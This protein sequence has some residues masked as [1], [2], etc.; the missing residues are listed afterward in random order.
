LRVKAV[1]SSFKKLVVESSLEDFQFQP[2]NKDQVSYYK[3][4]ATPERRLGAD[5]MVTLHELAYSLPE[6]VWSI[7]T[8]PDFVAC[9]GMPSMVNLVQSCNSVL[10]SYDTTFQL[11][12]FY[13]S[14]MVLKLSAFHEEPSIPVGFV[15]HDR[16]FQTVHEEF[17]HQLNRR[18]KVKSNVVLVSDG[19]A[20]ITSAFRVCYPKWFL[21]NCW[22]HILT[23]V[24]MWLKRH[25][26]KKSDIEVYKSNVRELLQCT[27]AGEMN[28]KFSTLE[29][30]WSE[31]FK[32]YYNSHLLDRVETAYTGYLQS[33]GLQKNSITTNMSESLN[34]VIKDFQSWQESTADICLLSM[35]RLQ[36]YYRVV[37][38][39]SVEGFGPYSLLVDHDA[40]KPIS[41]IML[42][43]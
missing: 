19:E 18:L 6:F 42:Y 14:V 2:R 10:L 13:L 21:V 23:D 33:V 22:N 3:C 15:L 37:I 16:K 24:E 30:S 40:G 31:S 29:P 17:C 25:D 20:A 8:F 39:R 27:S 4:I 34:F 9:F 36:L 26:G 11:G 38:L 35:Y 7:K 5:T 41:E 32:T 1:A 43:R 12:D 28:T